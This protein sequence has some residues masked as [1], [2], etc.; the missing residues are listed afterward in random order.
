[1]MNKHFKILIG[2]SIAFALFGCTRES[3]LRDYYFPVDELKEGLVYQYS[4]VGNNRQQPQHWFY[5]THTINDKQLLSCQTYDQSGSVEQFTLEEITANRSLATEYRLISYDS[6][7]KMH[8]TNLTIEKNQ[9]FPFGKPDKNAI[10]R[11]KVNWN[12]PVN[13]QYYNELNRGRAFH[14]F[15]QHEF[16]GKPVDCAE[17]IMVETIDVEQK[18]AG[19]QTLET[20]TKEL[21]AKGLGLI[22]YQKKTG[23]KT[24][25]TY[26]LTDRISMEEFTKKFKNE[27]D[28]RK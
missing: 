7:G 19:V 3:D 11:F 27:L 14:Q 6:T 9:M 25:Y 17:F 4:P 20:T 5:K 22:Y 28:K 12:D 13:T 26:Q 23:D 2:I 8:T 10:Q 16:K 15:T 18:D 1:M 24:L 21:Y